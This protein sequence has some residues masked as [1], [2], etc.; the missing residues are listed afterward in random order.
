MSI[1]QYLP[2]EITE[3][4]D[5]ST[6]KLDALNVEH[7]RQ[8]NHEN[9]KEK[10]QSDLAFLFKFKNNE[11]GSCICHVENQTSDDPTLLLRIRHY[12]TA[13]LLDFAKR[14]PNKK[15]PIIFSIIYY[16]SDKKFSKST[17]ILDYFENQTLRNFAFLIKFV[18]FS[19][20]TDQELSTHGILSAYELTFKHIQNKN[21]DD[22][23]SV[24]ISFLIQNDTITR[25]VLIKYMGKYSDI[26]FRDF[27]DRILLRE[28]EL[29]GDVMTVAEQLRQEGVQQGMQQGMKIANQWKDEGLQQ[30]MQRGMQQKAKETARNLLKK[31]MKISDIMEITG[32]DEKTI[33]KLKKENT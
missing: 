28:N 30:G 21:L 27:C 1:K 4:I 9:L 5:F 26:S 7:V 14:N 8:Q 24:I 17:D 22:N 25:Q 23:L 12:Q 10:E 16:A 6:L 2:I 3:N 15:L 29:K 20:I 11:L 13:Y 33:L 19:T 18:D 31:G 32:L